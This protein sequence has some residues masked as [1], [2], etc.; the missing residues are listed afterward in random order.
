MIGFEAAIDELVLCVLKQFDGL[1]HAKIL[2]ARRNFCRFRFISLS[3]RGIYLILH[4]IPFVALSM[5]RENLRLNCCS[6]L[7]VDDNDSYI[8]FSRSATFVQFP[9]VYANIPR[10]LQ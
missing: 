6:E 9:V 2:N 5:F 7:F 1:K 10:N 8:A 3:D 4:A